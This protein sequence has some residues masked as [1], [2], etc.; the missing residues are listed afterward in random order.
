[1]N[2]IRISFRSDVQP[3]ELLMSLTSDPPNATAA[4]SNSVVSS[5]NKTK[6][7][8]KNNLSSKTVGTIPCSI[9]DRKFLNDAALL[10]HEEDKHKVGTLIEISS[11]APTGDSD[12]HSQP[13]GCDKPTSLN[14]IAFDDDD[15][16]SHA[17]QPNLLT[18]VTEIS[19]SVAV[20]DDDSNT[21]ESSSDLNDSVWLETNSPDNEK[22]KEIDVAKQ[23]EKDD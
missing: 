4:G 6:K 19:H 20:S 5:T 18:T 14:L 7:P 8:K 11:S 12:H 21:S 17:S 1:M 22:P 10:Q 16:D 2:R 9:C 3:L 23:T 13:F 15:D